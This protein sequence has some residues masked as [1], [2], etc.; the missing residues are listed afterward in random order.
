[1]TTLVE[2]YSLGASRGARVETRPAHRPS[3]AYRCLTEAF[4]MAPVVPFDDASPLIFFSD[5]HRGDNSK[6]DAF[7]KN[8]P[9]FLRVLTGYYREGYT[10]VEVGDGDELWQHRCF[11]QVRAAHRRVFDLLHALEEDKR[12]HLIVGNHDIQGGR[13]EPVV[14][15]GIATHRGLILRHT[16]TGKRLFAVHGHQ[17]DLKS[18]RF[19]GIAR[20]LVR[21]VWRRIQLLGLA[22]S[23]GW[24]QASRTRTRVGRMWRHWWEAS[25]RLIERRLLAWVRDRDQITICGHTHRAA[26]AR[27]GTPPYFNAGSCTSPGYITGLEILDGWIRLV[28][29]SMGSQ[30]AGGGIRRELLAPPRALHSIV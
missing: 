24:M 22:D 29:W 5:C 19:I 15:D 17:A 8:E 11:G 10:Y 23:A 6:A 28:K 9:L 18:D 25:T 27:P 1:M 3:F 7:T 20:P 13:R 21:H 4:E 14:K 2:G 12:L 30:G 26:S 16:E